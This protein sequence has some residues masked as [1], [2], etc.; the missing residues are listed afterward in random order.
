MASILETFYILFAT[1]AGK[2]R[3]DIE[4]ADRAAEKMA[5][6]LDKSGS[7]LG[8]AARQAGE[9]SAGLDRAGR[10]AAQLDN[11]LDGAARAADRVGDEADRAGRE[12]AQAK[13]QAEAM[14]AAFGGMLSRVLAVAGAVVGLGQAVQLA[15][16]YKQLEGQ[17]KLTAKTT[18][19]F[20]TAQRGVFDISQR[21]RQGL[22]GTTQLY[23]SLQR[24]TES[25]GYSQ[26]RLLGVTETIN[27]A[28]TVSGTS[29]EAAQAALMQLGQGF[30]SGTLRGE[31]LNSVLE[32]APRLAKAIADG[33]GVSVGQLRK[34]GEEG[35][36]TADTVFKALESQSGAIKKEFGQ[37]GVTVGSSLTV[38]R[39][40]SVKFIGELDKGLHVTD[41]LARGITVL[42]DAV[43]GL[44]TWFKENAELIK[45]F[46]IGLGIA[47]AVLTVAFLPAIVATTVAL[48][49]MAASALAIAAPFIAIGVAVLAAAAAFAILWEDVQAFLKGQPS[50]LGQLVEQYDF[51]RLAVEA[52]GAAWDFLTETVPEAA[53]AIGNAVS[54]L[55]A[56]IWR[57]AGPVFDL[58]VDA[59]QLWASVQATVAQFIWATISELFAKW[60][61][62]I[63]PV[64]NIVSQGIQTVGGVF[65]AVANAIWG[66]WGKMFDDLVAKVQGFV[67]F[68]R[69]G[70]AIVE[71][72]RGA[73][74]RA[75]PGRT[76][77]A[78]AG[79]AAGRGQLGAAGRSP[80]A[81]QT[82]GAVAAR[83]G[84]TPNR[85]TQVHVGKV[86]VHTQ[87]TDAQGMAKAA[88]GALS[89]EMRRATAQHE[90]G[91]DR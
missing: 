59:I 20:E 21:T 23:A 9:V 35:K 33:M 61:P 73:V 24:S 82:P 70:M 1:D 53:A 84:V 58:I 28:I 90:D 29:A 46:G 51:V 38:L 69:G 78:V 49:G 43:G 26:D 63:E 65:A 50:L 81:A 77:P 40:A 80:L 57:V 17:I 85:N 75:T 62:Y 36:I 14:G 52:I 67:N 13:R 27:Q 16:E 6:D 88:G 41:N 34:L 11:E 83:G 74:E 72:M 76:A 4:A 2:A 25:L 10:E 7:E 12:L 5:K 31:E 86:E 55:F 48:W 8:T 37:M 3:T 87:A 18:A 15:D 91:V 60:W 64:F 42:A 47:A 89:S 68:V 32:Q 71:G 44:F 39:N 56:Q 54:E 79:V 22:A 30:A 45:G 19:E 66:Q